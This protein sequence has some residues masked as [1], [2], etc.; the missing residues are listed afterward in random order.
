[1]DIGRNPF[2]QGYQNTLHPL[3]LKAQ[4]G[5]SEVQFYKIRWM[6]A[7]RHVQQRRS[8]SIPENSQLSHQRITQVITDNF[9]VSPDKVGVMNETQSRSA[10]LLPC[11][12]PT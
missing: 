8:S 10:A 7:I 2:L 6:V 11:L 9:R 1:M 4:F 3:L 5:Q 12:Q